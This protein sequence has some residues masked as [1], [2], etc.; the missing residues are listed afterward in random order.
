MWTLGCGYQCGNL[1]NAPGE[2]RFELP[3]IIERI[4]STYMSVKLQTIYKETNHTLRYPYN[5]FAQ[6]SSNG[7]SNSRTSRI[8]FVDLGGPETDELDGAA[9]IARRSFISSF[10]LFWGSQRL[11]GCTV[12]TNTDH[13]FP[14]MELGWVPYPHQ[15][16]MAVWQY[17]HITNSSMRL[18]FCHLVPELKYDGCMVV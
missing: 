4:I 5:Y 10:T 2:A 1:K 8:T 9:S 6:G 18:I 11:V 7:F 15:I 14:R 16:A 3:V 12:T 17:G 13:L